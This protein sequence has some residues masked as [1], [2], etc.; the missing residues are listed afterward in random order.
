MI[1]IIKVIYILFIV[2]NFV[3]AF[4]VV[5]KSK[6][7]K[8]KWSYFILALILNLWLVANYFA[9]FTGSIQMTA[10]FG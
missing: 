1:I 8:I 2:I 6:Q 5:F 9:Y 4:L 7:Q 3:V 10:I